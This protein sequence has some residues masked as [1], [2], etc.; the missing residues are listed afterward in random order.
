MYMEVGWIEGIRPSKCRCS[1]P[2]CLENEDCGRRMLIQ[3]CLEFPW[4]SFQDEQAIK[5]C[6]CVCLP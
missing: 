4:D 3:V 2:S 1:G 5:W 6:V